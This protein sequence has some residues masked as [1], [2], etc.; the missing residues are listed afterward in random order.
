[1]NGARLDEALGRSA[2]D[3]DQAA[4]AARLLE[5]ADVLAKLLGQ[6]HLVL[7]LFH[8]RSVDLLDVVV[9]EDGLHR[10]DGAE[11]AFHFVEQVAL[12]HSGV[13]GGGVHVVFENVPAG[14]DQIV[15]AGEGNEILD[16]GRDG[17]RCAC[18]GGS[19]PICVSEPMGWAIPFR[20]AS[21]PATNVVATAPM[22]GINDAQ[23][24]LGGLD[25][26]IR[27]PASFVDDWRTSLQL[28]AF[29]K[30]VVGDFFSFAIFWL[31]PYRNC[32]M[33]ANQVCSRI[34]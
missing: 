30:S 21:T 1:M 3:G 4:G 5:V 26:A 27:A 25:R 7:A 20:T 33:Y 31:L 19:V 34:R 28:V 15:E 32:G 18:R 6:V 13:A 9:I 11:A 22:P 12:Q 17:R 23:L 2:P 14:E 29:F 16:L 8:V 24:A 10:S